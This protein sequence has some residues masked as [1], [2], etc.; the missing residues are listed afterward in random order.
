MSSPVTPAIARAVVPTTTAG[1][2][3][4]F[5][6]AMLQ[7]PLRFYQ[8]INWML[9]SN[10][11]VSAAFRA[12]LLPIGTIIHKAGAQPAGNWLECIGQNVSRTTY[13][14]LFTE[15][16]TT[17]GSGDG[18]T[19]FGVP[20]LRGRSLTGAGQLVNADASTGLTYTVGQKAGAEEVVLVSAEVAPPNLNPGID[21]IVINDASSVG[22]NATLT[23]AGANG[24]VLTPADFVDTG[25][26]VEGHSNVGPRLVVSAWI[27]Y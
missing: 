18:T 21:K 13:A 10:G 5:S 23:G 9:D 7:L 8:F 14:D 6:K 17:Y 26:D 11:N 15:I 16:S 12:Q 22:A 1:K 4:S 19:T 24:K 3:L 2:C 25:V 20:D 27:R